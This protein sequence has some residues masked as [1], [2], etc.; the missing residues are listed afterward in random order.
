MK[1][2][3]LLPASGVGFV[4]NN[5]GPSGKFQFGQ[6]STIDAAVAVGTAWNALNANH[7]FSIGQISLKGGGEMPPHRSHKV[8][9]DVDVRPMRTDGANKP[10]NITD[11]AYDRASTT[12]VIT[13]WW[14][15]AP[16]QSLFFND[17]T[18]I[19]AGLSQFVNGHHHHFHVRLRARGATIRIGDRGSDVGEV[20]AKLG[21]EPD[22]R[23]GSV[24]QD[25]VEQF[26]TNHD[27]IPDGVVGPKTW[28]A[29]GI[30]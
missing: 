11:S 7:P 14:K 5:R 23:F 19:A 8:G 17:Q 28:E 21:L 29:L 9:L 15:K 10:V 30:L 25:A 6:K 4:T 13:L 16:V 27:L 26:Q 18:V 20:Q 3:T 24:T 22:C 1:I 2:T 12:D